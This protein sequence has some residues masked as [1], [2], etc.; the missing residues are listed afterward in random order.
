M[1]NIENNNIDMLQENPFD[2]ANISFVKGDYPSQKIAK[3]SLKY[4][5]RRENAEKQ[6]KAP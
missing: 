4:V 3:F 5:R 1:G 6:Y 2:T